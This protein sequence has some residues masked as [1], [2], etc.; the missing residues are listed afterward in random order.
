MLD[1]TDSRKQRSN[2]VCP[3][4]FPKAQELVSLGICGSELNIERALAEKRMVKGLFIK[5]IIPHILFSTTSSQVIVPS[6]QIN[7]WRL[8]L[9]RE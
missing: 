1:I 8:V 7:A 4:K 9:W 5:H 6:W 2:P 3:A